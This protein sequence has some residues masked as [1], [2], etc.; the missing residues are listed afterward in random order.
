MKDSC[1]LATLCSSA[2]Y[3]MDALTRSSPH[4]CRILGCQE[5]IFCRSPEFGLEGHTNG[6][7]LLLGLTVE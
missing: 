6:S 4:E 3:V 2:V 1:N 7:Y 5:H